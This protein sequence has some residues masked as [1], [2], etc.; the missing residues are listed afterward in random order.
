[1]SGLRAGLGGVLAVLLAGACARA[2]DVRPVQVQIKE[3]EPGAFLV[4]WR[5]PKL[6]P[7]EAIPSPVLPEGCRPEGKR[8]VLDQPSGWLI[9]QVVRCPH[10]VAGQTI[11]I[12]YPIYNPSLTTVIRVELL[13]GERF[14]RALGPREE[15]WRVPGADVGAFE[16][17]L[18]RARAAV[19]TGLTH[20]LGD[21]VHLAFLLVLV[22]LGGAAGSIRLVT[23]FGIGQLVAVGVT[24][25]LGRALD[26][27]V[28]EICSAIALVFLARE[29]L[30]PVSP[31]GRLLG[32]AAGAGLFHGVA[33]GTWLPA[34][35]DPGGVDWS[36]H[37][38]LVLGMDA[39]LLVLGLAVAVAGRL[40]ARA[41][42]IVRL[43]P[44]VTYAIG[45]AGVAAALILGFGSRA[46]EA[47]PSASPR[48]LGIAPTSSTAGLPGSRR[49][50]PRSAAAPIQSYLAIEPFEIRHEVLI[51]LRDVAQEIDLE[52]GADG[53]LEIEAQA[54]VTRR[55][56]DLVRSRTAV[57]IDGRPAERA[58]LDRVAF[59]T[60]DATGVLPRKSPVREPIDEARVGVTI[61]YVT[62]GMP[63]E[64]TLTWKEIGKASPAIPVTVIDPESTRSTK[65]TAAQP[66]VRWKNELM[67]N[68]IPTVA[69][70]AI[71][72]PEV[73]VPLVSA[74]LLAAAVVLLVLGARGRRRVASFAATRVV[75]A[76]ALLVAPVARVAV[77]L[78]AAIGGP[79]SSR[80]AQRILASVLP[81]VYRAFELREETAAYDRL[82]VAVT[83]ETL[84]QVY[85]QH[86]RSLE[87]AERGG[88]RA[89]VDAVEVS[90]VR[91]IEP[92][93]DGGFD[94]DATWTVGG[95]VTHFGHRHFRQNRYHARVTV[96]PVDGLWKIRS[97][98]VLEQERV[99]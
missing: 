81:N 59:V 22:L 66:V 20:I 17:W 23:A 54:D 77:T 11:G 4:Q 86:R 9:R 33:L 53:L 43:R 42:R 6:L 3:R 60:A 83:G 14:V 28:A 82:A 50:A 90:G 10:G 24:A 18:K 64:A 92:K 55:L 45:G 1:M 70:A 39:T 78:P 32:I 25:I 74:A 19:R 15:S 27:A 80:Q 71:E 68:P 84:T 5:V 91:A 44:V 95:T 21:W 34:A 56:A 49:L 58:I 98:E 13:S 37:L 38:V 7:P 31:R 97:L 29:A 87:L 62:R 88:A 85:L 47:R 65:L 26:P 96:V 36:M 69:G 79:V 73:P 63:D 67:E 93:D 52:V 61:A 89:R 48:P 99:K 51:R 46:G 16:G 30:R 12:R 94:V 41:G 57:A 35:P 40:L 8:V 2:D 76:F 75:L 72:P